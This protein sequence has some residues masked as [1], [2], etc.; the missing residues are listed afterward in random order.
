MRVMHINTERGF[1]GGE[2][3]VLYLVR[4]LAERG[5]AQ[6]VVCQRGGALAARLRAAGVEPVE[7]A[8]GGYLDLGSSRR[9]RRRL[10]AHPVEVLHLHTAQAHAIGVRAA[11]G[12]GARRPRTVVSR[13]VSYSIYRHSF[14]GLNRLK[15][16]R[17]VD[18]I[19]CVAEA[20]RERLLA[21]GLGPER[22][23]VVRSGVDL[24]RLRGADRGAARAAARAR[25]GLAPDATLLGHVGALTPEKGHGVL[26]EAL[27]PLLTGPAGPHLV[28]VGEGPRRAAVEAEVRARGLAGRVH[29]AG[30]AADTVP[31]LLAF[32]LFVF[33]SLIEGIGGTLIEALGA[34]LPCVA[35]RT[36]GLPEVARDEVEALLVPP[37]DAG[38]LRAAVGRLL[39]DPALGAR[40]GAAGR[41]RVEERFTVARMVEG[42]LAAY[43]SLLGA[44]GAP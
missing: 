14:L 37:G 41:R 15:Y 17:G 11:R 24:E 36:G 23:A 3:Q 32:D 40:L 6:E 22:L 39:G 20:V 10:R 26:L 4:G 7:L 31:W 29:L 2:Q 19:L 13:R 28:L 35:S 25:L 33:P 9:I 16:T 1:R 34:A 12:L 44:P 8:L 5:V 18:L 21:D 43:R 30:F 38:A 42:T 27:A